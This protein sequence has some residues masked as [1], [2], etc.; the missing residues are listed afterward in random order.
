MKAYTN[1][2]VS[3]LACYTVYLL[4]IT[5][6]WEGWSFGQAYWPI[7]CK[8]TCKQATKV[9]TEAKNKEKRPAF[10]MFEVFILV[11]VCMCWKYLLGSRTTHDLVGTPCTTLHHQHIE[12]QIQYPLHQKEL[13]LSLHVLLLIRWCVAHVMR[14]CAQRASIAQASR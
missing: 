13:S 9:S 7:Y 5:I 4:P 11:A 8:H 12:Q 2:I 3:C 6:F 10:Q 14:W 1:Y